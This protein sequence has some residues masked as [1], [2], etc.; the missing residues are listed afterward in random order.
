MIPKKIH[1]IWVNEN[2][3]IPTKYKKEWIESWRK[4]NPNWEYKL[5]TTDDCLDLVKTHFKE[6]LPIYETLRPIKKA[7]VVRLLII[8]IHGGVYVDLD[9]ICLRTLDDY[10]NWDTEKVVYNGSNSCMACRIGNVYL[11][12]YIKHI[13]S[14]KKVNRVLLYAG[15]RSLML[16]LKCTG[17]NVNFVYDEYICNKNAVRTEKTIGIHLS[18]KG[19]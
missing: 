13:L 10:E 19:W 5:W 6:Y 17:N 14:K 4:K 7:D 16:W 8:Y 11:G 18:V 2:P 9:T 1:Q 15:P 12:R 3:E